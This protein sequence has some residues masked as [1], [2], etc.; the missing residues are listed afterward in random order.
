MARA[1]DGWLEANT[2]R[3]RDRKAW[4][5]ASGYVDQ[6]RDVAGVCQGTNKKSDLKYYLERKRRTGDYHGQAPILRA[7]R[8][9]CCASI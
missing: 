7:P 8:R 5:A 4:I 3:P 9:R 2:Y 1:K 6:N